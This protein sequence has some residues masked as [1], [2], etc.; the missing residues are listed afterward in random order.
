M[1]WTLLDVVLMVG[2]VL[3]LLAL[4]AGLWGKV[5]TVRRTTVELRER[6]SGLSAE[7][8]ALAGRLDPDGVL[9]RLGQGTG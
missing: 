6:V 2:S 4:A 7:T 1:S 3:L 8:S 9:G 5:K